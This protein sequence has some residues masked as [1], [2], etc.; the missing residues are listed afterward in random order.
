MLDRNPDVRDFYRYFEIPG[1]NHCHGGTGQP[2]QIFNQLRAWVEN[3]TVPDTTPYQITGL[4]RN[5]EQRI[6]CPY[7]SK[8]RLGACPDQARAECWSCL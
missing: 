8:A 1:M 2:D 7:P 3:G 6:A 4:T 5:T